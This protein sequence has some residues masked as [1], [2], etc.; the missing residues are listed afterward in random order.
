MYVYATP[1]PPIKNLFNPSDVLYETFLKPNFSLQEQITWGVLGGV[2]TGM[3]KK[4]GE[5]GS[6]GEHITTL[7]PRPCASPG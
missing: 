4:W 2:C 6:G 7:G 3:F 1:S 5:V